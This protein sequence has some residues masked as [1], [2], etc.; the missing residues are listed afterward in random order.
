MTVR[1]RVKDYE[2]NAVDRGLLVDPT[3]ITVEEGDRGKISVVLKRRPKGTVAVGI[4]Q[5]PAGVFAVN[6]QIMRFTPENWSEPQLLWLQAPEDD[7][8]TD[9]TAVF[10]FATRHGGYNG[11]TPVTVTARVEDNDDVPASSESYPTVSIGDASADEGNASGEIFFE[12][13]L[14]EPADRLAAVDFRTVAGGTASVG[15]DYRNEW[16]TV[17]I[18][19]GRTSTL[20]AVQIFD[21]DI[22]DDGETLIVEISN[23]RL[24]TWTGGRWPRLDIE[25]A[26]A[27]GTIHNSDPLPKDWLARFGRTVAEHVLEAV[28]TRTRAPRAPG[29]ALTL[30]GQQAGAASAERELGRARAEGGLA[31]RLRIESDFDRMRGLSGRTMTEREL[32]TGSSFALAGGTQGTGFY[33]LWG[34]GAATQFDGRE[35]GL[36]LDGE[37]ASGMLGADWT[38]GP[39]TAGLAVSRSRG[40]GSYRGEAGGG[41]ITSSLTGVYPWGGYAVN[42]RL[43]LW[44]VTG[45][46]EGTLT[47]IPEG[48]API[49]TDL[50]LA[51]AAAG[52]RSVLA[53]ASETGGIELALKSDAMGVRT[54]TARARGLEAEETE[55]TRLRLGLEGSR[56]LPFEGGASLT[57]SIEF[58]ARHDGGD[59]ETG[60]GVE[61]GGGLAWSDPRTG[62]SAELRA[63][64]LLSHAA[65]G[66]REHGVSGSLSWDPTPAS[67]RGLELTMSQTVG[68]HSAS[69]M[70]AIFEQGTLARLAA[71]DSGGDGDTLA[72]RG[73]GIRLGYGL[74]AFGD[75]FTS[76]P[77][78]GFGL[79]NGRRD[80]SL[81]WRLM[82][83]GR[84]GGSL[85]LSLEASLRESANDNANPEHAVGARLSARF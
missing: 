14:S 78:L 8:A 62:L 4:S 59:A 61:I 17:F 20:A 74:A 11:L 71:G 83:E 27:T 24:V 2:G 57:P 50:D 40:D 66:F 30:A 21:D 26:R 32:L 5:N 46:G 52:L 48:Q 64:G 84:Y 37:V 55:V 33:T 3:D 19:A 42:D 80:Y 68:V 10:T 45:F 12:V 31:D 16:Y 60:F 15:A 73:Y 70:D 76:K 58:G 39:V 29:A 43:S 34:R 49:E 23:A 13:S 85:G 53:E 51:M 77:E 72:Q 36:S 69:G 22:D 6:K 81:G 82:R 56:P 44:A 38:G 25:T 41:A 9:E 54:S 47:L 7:D 79:S 63:R 67:E 28:E 18:P 75:G 1:A 65:E 35:G